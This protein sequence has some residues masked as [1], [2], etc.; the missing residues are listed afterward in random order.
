MLIVEHHS[1]GS[2]RDRPVV[3]V[4][5]KEAPQLNPNHGGGN[6][7]CSSCGGKSDFN[8]KVRYINV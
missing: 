5:A 7:G 2:R 4:A 1:G 6:H 8:I 3:D